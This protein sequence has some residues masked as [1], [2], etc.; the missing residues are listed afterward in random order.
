MPEDRDHD[1]NKNADH[2]RGGLGGICNDKD[3]FPSVIKD[4]KYT[5]KKAE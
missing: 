5:P 3:D 1:Q 2:C 4:I